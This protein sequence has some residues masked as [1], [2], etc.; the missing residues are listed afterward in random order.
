MIGQLAKSFGSQCIVVAIDC[1]RQI[2][3]SSNQLADVFT[4]GGRKNTYLDVIHWAKKVETL[5][6]GE[7][8]LTSMDRD[9]TRIGFDIELTK[10]VS[11]S[12]N[13]PVIASGGAGNPSTFL[14]VLKQGKADAALA[15][16]SFH[17][18]QYPISVV[19]QYL[20]ENGVEVRL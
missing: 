14:D 19:K 11:E 2:D 15:A 8:L 5:G 3:D 6:A 13:I 12:V 1:K 7:I 4:Y 20:F 18:D 16:S 9:G 10:N 17:Y